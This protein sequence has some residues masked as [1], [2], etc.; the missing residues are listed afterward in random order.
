MDSN[1]TQPGDTPPVPAEKKRSASGI[2]KKKITRLGDFKLIKKLGQGGMGEVY[3]AQQVSLDRKV[4]LKTLSRNLAK[5]PAFVERF[6]RE[7]RAMAKLQH[8]NIVQVYAA[9]SVNS[10]YFAAIEFIDGQSMQDWMND[11]GKLSVADAVHVILVCAE[12]LQQAHS[13]NIVHRD[14]KPDNILVTKNGIVKVAD[15]GLAKALGEDVSMTQ[16][17]TGLGTPLYM[18]PEQARNAKNV[19]HRADIYALGTMLYFFV[20]NALPYAG[21]STLELIIAKE[22]GKFKPAKSLNA[23][24]P[25]RLDLMIDKMMAKEP[26]HRYSSCEEIIHNLESLNLAS[27]KLSFIDGNA[28]AVRRSSGAS[29]PTAVGQPTKAGKTMPARTMTSLEDATRQKEAATKERMW[30]VESRNP[31][32]EV[33]I[34]K[35]PTSRVLQGIKAGMFDSA[36]ARKAAKE[37]FLPLMQFEE[38]E[39]AMSA[40]LAKVKA[41][42][43]SAGM[44]EA[45]EQIDKQDRRIKRWR[46]LKRLGGNAL[47]GFGLIIWIVAALA[48][49]YGLFLAIPWAFKFVANYFG[50]NES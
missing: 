50:L 37:D 7:S 3:L 35:M 26:E 20:T 18:A 17:G 12:A 5:Q 45:Y 38:F 13:Q 9:D 44:K 34:A 46:W 10:I 47:G 43:R 25:E 28:K 14:I 6:L 27:S 24:V 41:N 19:D 31:K 16:S 11:V 8:P 30:M 49:L 15:F 23:E 48:A 40:R 1:K 32:G 22:T 36:R 39:S 2:Q 4:A 42:Q 21:D 29:P 33:S